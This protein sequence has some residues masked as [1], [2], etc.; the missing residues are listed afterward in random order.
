MG[1]AAQRRGTIASAGGVAVLT[2]AQ[3]VLADSP[4]AYWKF[5][6]GSGSS[7]TDYSG[8]GL[9][10]TTHNSPDMT[11]AGMLTGETACLFATA[12]SQYADCPHNSALNQGDVFTIEAWVKRTNNSFASH[13][14]SKVTNTPGFFINASNTLQ[15]GVYAVANIG[16]G[17]ILINDTN[18]HHLVWT[19]NGATNLLYVDAVEGHGSLSN[20]TASNNSLTANIGQ[21][22]D[23]SNKMNGAMAHVALYTTALSGARISA[24][25]AA[26]T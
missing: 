8:N 18:W 23:G 9:T 17:S 24:H 20:A 5:N 7:I 21:N 25:Y 14:Y 6:E 10:A 12:S 15:I 4:V 1:L 3:Q 16:D 2:Y 22:G 11:V 26:R 13:I 19:K